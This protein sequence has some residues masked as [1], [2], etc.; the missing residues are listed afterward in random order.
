MRPASKIPGVSF[1]AAL[2][3]MAAC[4][5]SPNRFRPGPQ[6]GPTATVSRVDVTGPSSIPPGETAQFQATAHFSDGTS[7]DVTG[8]A[9][10]FSS[11]PAVLLLSSGGVATARDR[12]E[13][14]VQVFLSGLSRTLPVVVLPAGTFRLAGRVTE[15]GVATEFIQGARVEAT[16][17]TGPLLSTMTGSDGRY[18][19][20]GVAA[21]AEIRVTREGYEPH[22]QRLLLTD[23]HT[24]DIELRLTRPRAD[25]SGQYTLTIAAA[26][27]CSAALPEQ[28]RN[29]TYT[30]IVSQTA[31]RLNVT[32]ADATFFL[33]SGN[34]YNRFQGYNDGER[35]TFF[36]SDRSYYYWYY[37]PSVIEQITPE[38]FLVPAGQVTGTLSTSGVAGTLNG[39]VEVR[40][41]TGLTF[42]TTATCR[43]AD[44]RFVLER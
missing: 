32:L 42:K 43:S 26:P 3:L 6:P 16:V 22:V 29:R 18:R 5:S 36:L 24:L 25:L 33:E 28:A 23:H 13:A 17:G 19:L 39:V 37:H 8:E 14:N 34:L 7:R 20:Y 15:A 12:G 31:S 41:R 9:A 44:H 11:N 1:A 2:A 40:E 35:V 10:W 4:D 21:D 38:L 27:D 30:A